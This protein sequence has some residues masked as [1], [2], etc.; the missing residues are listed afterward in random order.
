MQV[1]ERLEELKH[2]KHADAVLYLRMHIAQ[3][4]L[5]LGQVAEVKKMIED[6]KDSLDSLLDVRAIP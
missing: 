3:F 5:Q 6:G 4:K 1:V 2:V